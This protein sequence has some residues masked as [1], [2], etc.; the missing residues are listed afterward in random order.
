MLA[1]TPERQRCGSR[2]GH[3]SA[4]F[5][6]HFRPPSRLQRYVQAPGWHGG[7][8]QMLTDNGRLPRRGLPPSRRQS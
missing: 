6:S 2:L 8:P 5:A 3:E 4:R 7:V 1:W